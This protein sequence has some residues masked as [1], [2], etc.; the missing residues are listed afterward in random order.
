MDILDLDINKVTK[1]LEPIHQA[2]YDHDKSHLK[3]DVLMAF[4]EAARDMLPH[5][6]INLI[7]EIAEFFYVEVEEY[8]QRGDF[9]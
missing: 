3:F 6:M 5:Q 7:I 8:I 2:E 9:I 4:L 1:L